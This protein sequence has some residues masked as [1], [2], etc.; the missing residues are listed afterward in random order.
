M[1]RPFFPAL[2]QLCLLTVCHLGFL[3]P[4]F[5]PT[6]FLAPPAASSAS[7]P[8][9]HSPNPLPMFF[10]VTPNAPTATPPWE[11]LFILTAPVPG[12][13]APVPSRGSSSHTRFLGDSTS[14]LSLRD[15]RL[16]IAGKWPREG[17]DT[18]GPMVV[19]S[20]PVIF[21]QH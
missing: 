4:I 12:F 19:G 6:V 13:R 2:T 5:R 11:R 3:P 21:A 1:I 18:R 16:S 10:S 15:R 14:S 20:W 8:D 7:V 17:E 9:R